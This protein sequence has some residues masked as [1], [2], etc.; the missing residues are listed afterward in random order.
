[1]IGSGL[2]GSSLG[3]LL[4]WALDGFQEPTE[5]VLEHCMFF[6]EAADDRIRHPD[7]PARAPGERGPASRP[8]A[9]ARAA[10]ERRRRS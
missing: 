8:V 6:Y 2:F 4:R 1:M 10:G 5:T 9:R 3:I 7:A